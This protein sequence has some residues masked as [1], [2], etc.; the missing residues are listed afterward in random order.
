MSLKIAAAYIRVSTDDQTEL[1]PD[2]QVKKIQEYAK[3]HGYIVPNEY[4]FH[5]DGISGRTTKKRQGFNRMIA[6]AKSDPKPFDAILVWKFSRFARNRE[7]SIVFKSMLKK[8]GIDVISISEAVGDDKMSILI[9]SL[10]EAMDEYYSVNLSEEVVRGMMEKFSRGQ[11]VSSPPFGYKMIDGQYVIDEDTKPYVLEIFKSYLD[12]KGCREIAQQ[13]NAKGIRT[14]RGNKFENRTVYYIIHNP[15][16]AGYIRWDVDGRGAR[17]HYRD[18]KE[19]IVKSNH[20]PYIDEET[21]NTLKTMFEAEK[22][23]AKKYERKSPVVNDFALRGLVRCSNCGGTLCMAASGKSLQCHKYAHGKCDV[24]HS[25][26]LNLI[27]DALINALKEDIKNTE[28]NIIPSKATLDV[29]ID[30]DKNIKREKD[31]LSRIKEA[32]QS[33]IDTLEEYKEN[34][35]KILEVISQL[36]TEKSE[37]INQF[38]QANADDLRKKIKSTVE[39]LTAT[40]VSENEKNKALKTF[41]DKIVFDRKSAQITIFYFL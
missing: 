12:G 15:V 38:P 25:I 1:S 11:A 23:N 8:R 33:G 20:E 14:K 29:T 28:L 24:S 18:G 32:Y 31:K 3:A 21:Y 7:D 4:I 22:K 6:I 34:K 9:E 17:S 10:I 2:S 19:M 37:Q 36:E 5:D 40:G 16:Y 39:L 41:I 30:Y 26:S 13:L 27:N 35:R